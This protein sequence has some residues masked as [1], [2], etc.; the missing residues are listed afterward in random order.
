MLGIRDMAGYTYN[1]LH[2]ISVYIGLPTILPL[3]VA[4]VVPIAYPDLN[5]KYTET[6]TVLAAIPPQNP[7]LLGIGPY[8]SKVLLI[9][10]LTARSQTFILVR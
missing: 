7:I 5:N 6:G 3:G 8:Q 1:A 4:M 10:E 9:P 2:S